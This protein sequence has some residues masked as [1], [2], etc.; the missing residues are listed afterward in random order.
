VVEG[1][2]D[3]NSQVSKIPDDAGRSTLRLM[4]AWVDGSADQ[5]KKAAYKF[6]HHEVVNGKPGAANLNGVNN[7]LA[8][9]P[10]ANIPD[11]DR[12]GVEAHLKRHQNA[13]KSSETKGYDPGSEPWRL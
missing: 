13:A 11:A 2:W 5:T 10:G 4:Y 6:P 12:A 7:A 8:R 9:L 3:A 1:T